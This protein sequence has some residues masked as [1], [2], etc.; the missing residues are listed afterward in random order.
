MHLCVLAKEPRPGFAKTRLCPPCTPEQA[1]ALAEACLADTLE[2]VRAT[3]ACPAHRRARRQARP[4]A[5]D[6]VQRG[7]PGRRRARTDV[8]RRVRAVLRGRPDDPV[9]LIGMDTPQVRSADLIHAGAHLQR[10]SD[11]VLGPRSTVATG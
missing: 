8:C 5:A 3:P 6:G 7:R 1:A 9:V 10:G 2:T 4:V 11:A